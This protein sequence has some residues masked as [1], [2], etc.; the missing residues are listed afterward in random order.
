M[1][2]DSYLYTNNYVV[3]AAFIAMASHE[4]KNFAEELFFF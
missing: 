4:H 1:Q 3:I 2:K